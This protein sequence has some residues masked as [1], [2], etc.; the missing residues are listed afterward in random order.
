MIETCY[1]EFHKNL[2]NSD[3]VFLEAF[4]MPTY[5]LRT[6][7]DVLRE[8]DMIKRV[9]QDQ[10]RVWEDFHNAS[11]SHRDTHA[12]NDRS[13]HPDNRKCPYSTTCDPKVLPQRLFTT[14]SNLVDEAKIVQES[15]RSPTLCKNKAGI[16]SRVE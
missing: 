14:V 2:G 13:S 4:E 16:R 5:C 9:Y 8:L 1:D 7:D 15:V 3:D 6:I 10:A 12:G 11:S